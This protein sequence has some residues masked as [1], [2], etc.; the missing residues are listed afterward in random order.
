M[1]D[2]SP[3][4]AR[5]PPDSGR[6]AG[7]N[8]RAKIATGLLVAVGLLNLAPGILALDPSRA[9][10]LYGIALEGD[11]LLVLMRHRAVLLAILGALLLTAA[12]VPRVRAVAIA[13]ALASKIAF[14]LLYATAAQATPELARVALLDAI[15]VA[16]LLLAA[17]LARGGAAQT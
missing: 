10:T 16:V 3:R 7:M 11:T 15:A 2:E 8:A 6:L 14:L 13:A 12:F 1:P 9:T 5:S 4:C 17:W